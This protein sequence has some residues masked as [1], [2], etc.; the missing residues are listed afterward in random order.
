MKPCPHVAIKVPGTGY[1]IPP[2]EQRRLRQQYRRRQF[3]WHLSRAASWDGS[4]ASPTGKNEMKSKISIWDCRRAI[5]IKGGLPL[6]IR[7]ALFAGPGADPVAHFLPK[8]V[9]VTQLEIKQGRWIIGNIGYTLRAGI[10]HQA[11][12]GHHCGRRSLVCLATIGPRPRELG[13]QTPFPASQR[14][15]SGLSASGWLVSRATWAE[16]ILRDHVTRAQWTRSRYHVKV[17]ILTRAGSG[18]LKSGALYCS[19]TVDQ[20]S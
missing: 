5:E 10:S 9:F 12:P 19:G 6:T 15:V 13:S 2:R 3:R 7:G 18:L 4:K 16:I 14:P 17:K 8:T 20:P 11:G 1:S